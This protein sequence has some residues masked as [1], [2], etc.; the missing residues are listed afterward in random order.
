VNPVVDYLG[1]VHDFQ[2]KFGQAYEG[3]PR[4]LPASVAALRKKLLLEETTELVLAI[5]RGELDEMLDAC[6]DL[7]YVV[8][9]TANAMGMRSVFDEAFTRVHLA[10]MKKV[11]AFSRHDS[12]RDSAHDIVKPEGWVKPDLTDLV[13]P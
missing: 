10:N 6:V 9:G 8:A 13:K 2:A 1:A 5:D 12:K 3:P 11:L 7:M 4:E